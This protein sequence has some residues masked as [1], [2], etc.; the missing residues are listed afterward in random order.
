MFLKKWPVVMTV[1]ALIILT[2]I[3]FWKILLTNLILTGVDIFLYFY[4]YKAYITEAIRHGRLPLW[5]PHLFMGAPLLANSQVGLFYPPNWLFLG[6]DV[7]ISLWR[8][9]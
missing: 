9:F 5:N 1:A 7:P 2:I 8:Q 6:L 3:F 4:P